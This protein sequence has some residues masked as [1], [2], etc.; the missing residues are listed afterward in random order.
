MES[1]LNPIKIEF[2]V[3]CKNVKLLSCVFSFSVKISNFLTHTNSVA[4]PDLDIKKQQHF[5]GSGSII[6]SMDP[7]PDP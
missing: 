5:A 6:F 1:Y 2:F 7:D 3:C 4:D